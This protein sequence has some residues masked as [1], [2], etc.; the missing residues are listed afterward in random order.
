MDFSNTGDDTVRKQMV[1]LE[2]G[3]SRTEKS[4]PLAPSPAA[5]SSTAFSRTQS[6]TSG[7]PS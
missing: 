5:T 3:L 7:E 4:P 6:I 1:D 2:Q